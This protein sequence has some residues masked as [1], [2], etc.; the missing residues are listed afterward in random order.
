MV[1]VIFEAHVGCIPAVLSKW[2]APTYFVAELLW[3][4]AFSSKIN[5]F[6]QTR[7]QHLRNP[8]LPKSQ[9]RR[10]Y[11]LN[12]DDNVNHKKI[13]K[14][15]LG[16]QYPSVWKW[17]ISSPTNKHES[18][19]RGVMMSIPRVCSKW[20]STCCEETISSAGGRDPRCTLLWAHLIK[21]ISMMEFQYE[22]GNV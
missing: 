6:T 18:Q 2:Q 16:R 17:V 14:T 8:S 1:F 5:F 15:L 21:H 4:S 20:Q 3:C 12:G 10:H 11:T 19:N 7:H 9:Q 22:N 13:A